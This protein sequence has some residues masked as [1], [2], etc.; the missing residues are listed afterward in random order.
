MSAPRAGFADTSGSRADGAQSTA[1]G[2]GTVDRRLLTDGGEERSESEAEGSEGGDE[3]MQQSEQGDA[4]EE[5]SEVEGDEGGG[6]DTEMAPPEPKGEAGVEEA[7]A[8][9]TEEEEAEEAAPEEAEAERPA[10]EE[11]APEEAEEGETVDVPQSDVESVGAT[12]DESTTVLFLDL[13]GLDLDLL[14]L[15]IE[16]H[17]LVLDVFATEGDGNLLGNLLSAVAGLTDPGGL[18]DLFPEASDLLPEGGLSGLLPG[19]GS[20]KNAL[21]LGG[22]EDDGE[23]AESGGFVSSAASSLRESVP[24]VPI[25]QLLI[26]VIA[27]VIKQLLESPEKEAEDASGEGT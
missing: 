22:G 17:Q 16:L 4:G 27:G 8:E 9:A 25:K 19:G 7:E 18:S 20:I 11:E 3:E 23:G 5:Q 24:S 26:E 2:E 1:A 12:D 15:E 21:G 13:Y 14:G 10:A 6:S